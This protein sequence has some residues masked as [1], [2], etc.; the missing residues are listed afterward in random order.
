MINSSPFSDRY[1]DNVIYLSSTLIFNLN[2]EM[3]KSRVILEP[4]APQS[5]PVASTVQLARVRSSASDGAINYISELR[6]YFRVPRLIREGYI[7]G[8]PIL[9]RKEFSWN[10]LNM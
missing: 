10:F 7:F 2:I 1:K 6:N 3:N 5:I 8:I 4:A 9:K